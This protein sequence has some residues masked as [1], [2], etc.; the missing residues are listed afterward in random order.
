MRACIA[1]WGTAVP[2]SRLTNH[3][4]EQRVDTSDAWIVERT[5]IRERRIAAP[6]ETTASLAIEAGTAAIKQAGIT[7]DDVELLIVATATPEQP[8][9]HTGAFVGDGLGLSCG[10]FDLAAGCAGFVYELVTGAALLTSGNL[11]YVLVIGAETLSR[12]VDPADRGT[13]IL[14]GDGAAAVVLEPSDD[15]ST[16]L[17]AWDLGCDGSATGL[18]EIPAGGSRLPTTP[19]TIAEGQ[20]FIKMQGQEV[21]RRAVRA[22]VNSARAALDRAGVSAADVHHFVPHQANLR[23]IEAAANRLKIP[24]ERTVVNIGQY[25]NTSAASI[26]LALAEAAESGR[27]AD[28]DLILLSGFGAGMTWGS[29]VLRWGR[30]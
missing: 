7:P 10:S 27:I 18:L 1:G 15:D 11:R 2:E 30:A 16:G 20:Q 17:L 3:D 26:P 6:D 4:L 13:C 29:A 8:I 21:F 24:S 12:I 19:A 9:P 14:F 5:G 23:I 28:G 22:V 25:G